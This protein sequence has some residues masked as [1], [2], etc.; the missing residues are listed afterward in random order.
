MSGR[1]TNLSFSLSAFLSHTAKTMI[2]SFPLPVSKVQDPFVV[3]VVK[4][5]M[6][7]LE[8]S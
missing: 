1:K 8:M 4:I 7:P 6:K 2:L 5:Y 3:V